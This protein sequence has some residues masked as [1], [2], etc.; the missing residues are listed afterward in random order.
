MTFHATLPIGVFDSGV[1]GLTVLKALRQALPAESFL[2]LGDTARLPYGTK[3]AHTVKRYARGA[4]QVLVQRGVKMLVVAC[5]TVSAVALEA[6][7]QAFAPLPVVG[8]VQPGAERAAATSRA[9]RIVVLA[10]ERTIEDGAYERAIMAL[11]PEAR[12]TGVSCPVFVSLAEEGWVSGAVATEAA[13]AYLRRAPVDVDCIVLGCTHFPPLEP[14]LRSALWPAVALVDSA[15]TTAAAVKRAL[16][17]TKLACSSNT[18]GTVTLLATDDR[19]RF[20]RVGGRFLGH[21]L[22]AEDI[23]LVDV[24][25]HPEG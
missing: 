16:A 6:L 24:Q 18:P 14:A 23:E 12:V 4:A 19:L 21:A 9:G 2:Y 5:N 25:A 7:T 1:G 11:R 13:R 20:A 15:E 3:S 10:T 22:R 17:T 8:V